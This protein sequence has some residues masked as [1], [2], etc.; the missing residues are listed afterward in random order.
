MDMDL[1]RILPAHHC[2][3]RL[4]KK[5]R[6][7][8]VMHHRR[9]EKVRRHGTIYVIAKYMLGSASQRLQGNIETIV[10]GFLKISKYFVVLG[11][12]T[13]IVFVDVEP[14][15][16][17]LRLA[18]GGQDLCAI[19]NHTKGRFQCCK[20]IRHSYASSVTSSSTR[21]SSSSVSKSAL[22]ISA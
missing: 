3:S 5:N 7:A 14:L 21:S 10:R 8:L 1:P 17:L 11:P 22:V 19:G 6:G 12:N 18:R 16:I 2:C 9:A 15:E 4:P 13:V 20:G